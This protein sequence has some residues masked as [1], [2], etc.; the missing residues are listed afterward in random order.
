MY[1]FSA[2][3]NVGTATV[4]IVPDADNDGVPDNIDNC[5]LVPNANQLD[6]DLDGVGDVCDACPNTVLGATVDATGCPPVFP[7][8]FDRN[9]AVDGADLM[10]F[11]ACITGPAVSGPPASGCTITQFTAADAN[12]D[13]DVD[14]ADFGIFQRCYSGENNPADSNCAQ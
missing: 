7:F 4:S 5:P 6:G 10:Q 8:D 11:E 12:G 9:G 3:T 13:N 2:G 14:Q 1:T